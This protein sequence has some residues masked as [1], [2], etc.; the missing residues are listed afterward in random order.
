MKWVLVDDFLL[1]TFP[2]QPPHP[3]SFSYDT[4]D[5]TGARISQTE[6]GDE[7]NSKTGSYSYQTPDGVYRTV[8]YVADAGGFRAT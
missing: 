2:T 8:N 3:Y 1:S 6:S 7:S 4:T 5:E